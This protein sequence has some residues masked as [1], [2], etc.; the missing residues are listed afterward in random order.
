M[1]PHK[2]TLDQFFTDNPEW[3]PYAD[4]VAYPPTAA[5]IRKE[6]PDADRDVLA[7]CQA[8][9]RI[10]VGTH[11]VRM[12]REGNT[13]RFAAM[14]ALQSPPRGE[15]TDTFWAGRKPWHEVYGERYANAVKAKLAKQGVN[16]GPN[17]E[18]MPELARFQGDREAVIP[19]EGA[20]SHMKNLCIRRGWAIE[21]ATTVEGREPEFDPLADEHCVPMAE[22][23]IRQGARRMIAKDP[24]L[25]RLPKRE[26]RERVLDKYGP[27]KVKGSMP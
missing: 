4:L 14:L 9:A 25:K 26:L 1:A 24:E 23:L 17:D 12:R 10:A 2:M 20:R 8:G 16:I 22:D 11:Y 7:H 5:E 3:R 6:F 27:S 21:G 13:D 19:F 18:Y 15:T